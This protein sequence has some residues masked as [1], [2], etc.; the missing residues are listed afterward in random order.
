MTRGDPYLFWQ[1]KQHSFLINSVPRFSRLVQELRLNSD[2][3]VRY[4]PILLTS[5]RGCT[6]AGHTKYTPLLS[7][8]EVKC[9]RTADTTRRRA[10]R[11][12][13]PHRRRRARP[14]RRRRPQRRRRQRAP[15]SI[16]SISRRPS[17]GPRSP[18]TPL[19]PP[20]SLPSLPTASSILPLVS[21]PRRLRRHRFLRRGLPRASTSMLCQP[22]IP[23]MHPI[24]RGVLPMPCPL[25]CGCLPQQQ[26][27]RPRQH[28]SQYYPSSNSPTSKHTRLQNNSPRQSPPPSQNSSP[29]SIF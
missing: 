6:W 26:R 17:T 29:K 28:P 2:Y 11:R 16:R 5:S 9:P 20:C 24:P 10:Q 12:R 27:R 4:S 22:W 21:R 13:R 25:P 3:P 8:V 14:S 18:R 7:S 23:A 19:I 1:H 15:R